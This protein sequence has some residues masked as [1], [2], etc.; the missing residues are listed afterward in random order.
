MRADGL[1]SGLRRRP[2]VT[3]DGTSP[4]PGAAARALQRP[5]RARRA[6]R[7]ARPGRRRRRPSPPR[8]P[9]PAAL[10]GRFEPVD[11]G[12]EF[13]RGRRLRAQARRARATSLRAAREL[14][15][16]HLIVVVGAGGDRDRGKRPLMG[17]AA[18]RH[19]D[20]AVITSDNPRSEDPRRSSRR[21][22]RGRRRRR[23]ARSSTA[24]QAI[25]HAIGLAGPGDVVVIAGKGHETYQEVERRRKVPFDDREVA[26]EALACAAGTLRTRVAERGGCA[27]RG[28]GRC[29]R[30]SDARGDRLAPRGSGRP[31]RRPARRADRRRALRRRRAQRPAPGACWWRRMG[32]TSRSRLAA[33]P[34][35]PSPIRWRALQQ[36][37][38]R[39]APR[40]GSAG[41]SASP[42]RPARPRPRTCSPRWSPSSAARSPTPPNLNTEIGLPLTVLSAPA[43][44]R[45]ARAGDGDARARPDRRA[46]RGSP[47]PTWA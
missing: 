41:R 24:T 4:L 27:A 26:R 15:T 12:Q 14:A 40:A 16:G 2:P 6:G 39:V 23:P 1:A 13:A 44:H 36:L 25:D 32:P 45:G 9:L 29:I 43:G 28:A 35:S 21:S 46:G 3:L 19:A 37:R 34:S 8:C 17:A 20:T 38:D 47:S 7:G 22:R 31:L 5:Q 10:P 30:R 33:A 11:V 18:A 42:A